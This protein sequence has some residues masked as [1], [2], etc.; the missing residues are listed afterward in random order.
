MRAE[1]KPDAPPMAFGFQLLLAAAC[2]LII[3]NVYYAQPILADIAAGLGIDA[4][5]RGVIV[6]MVQIGYCLGILFMVPLG[7]L[8]ENRRMI[9][10][11]LAGSVLALAG[12]AASDGATAFL[13]AMF[14]VGFFSSALQMIIP[15]AAGLAAERERGRV[16]GVVMGGAI[17]GI[18]LSRPVSSMVTGKYGW[19]AV[20]CMASLCMFLVWAALSLRLPRR[21]PASRGTGY[22]GIL[23]SMVALLLTVPG[24]KIRF[25]SVALAFS[26]FAI[27]WATAPL[28]LQGDLGLSHAEIALFSFVGGAAPLGVVIA[29]RLADRGLSAGAIAV[30]ISMAVIAFLITPL[31]GRHV[32]TLAFTAFLL[33]PGVN[34]TSVLV[35][36]SV[37]SIIPEA[38]NRL[39]ALCVACTFAGGA[40]G[41][42]LG[43][44]LYA[45][46]G[47]T[48][49][50]LVGASVAAMALGCHFLAVRG[51]NRG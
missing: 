46:F 35:Q 18:I 4:A 20:F 36:Q 39:N 42:A 11:M 3:A 6:T 16:L 9:S 44:W 26:G 17:L 22:N 45:G 50:A 31:F 30:G 43:P 15:L 27:F 25:L 37:L 48:V 29:G 24:L 51:K 41:S 33:D 12:V 32:V 14:F 8:V 2:C 23:R 1:A 19:R 38:R 13:A 5:A 34:V 28:T 21:E 10:I 40:V 49:T 7:D 47:W